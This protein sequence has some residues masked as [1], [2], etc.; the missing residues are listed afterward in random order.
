MTYRPPQCTEREPG[1]YEDCTWAS[2]VMLQNAA[3]GDAV[4]PSTRKEYE[5]LR[6]A[7]GDGPAENPGDGSNLLQLQVGFVSRY[8]WAP[9]RVGVPGLWTTF[10]KVWSLLAPGVGGVIQG[11]MGALSTHYRRWDPRFVGG[12]ASYVQRESS[13]NRVWWMNPLAPNSYAGEW[14]SK[15]DLRAFFVALNGGLLYARIGKFAVPDTGTEGPLVNF[16]I[17]YD[18]A[19]R[20]QP[21]EL[22]FPDPAASW[23]RL[24]D[25]TLHKVNT[26]WTKEGIRVRLKDPIIAGKPRTDD[27]MLGWLIGS[28]AA[29]ALDRNVN[30]HPYNQTYTV[31]LRVGGKNVTTGTVT[32][33]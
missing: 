21:A 11:K 33:P 27:W 15:A 18:A 17:L 22:T 12:H 6:V 3:H 25:N 32:L 29:F 28:D 14:M 30:A 2:G 24:A 10:D 7:G 20:I 31:D 4:V 16:T 9:D 1:G 26:G 19:G 5:A 13:A 23:L 8:K